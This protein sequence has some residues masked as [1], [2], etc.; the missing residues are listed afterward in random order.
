MRTENGPVS[1]R[2]GMDAVMSEEEEKEEILVRRGG[3]GGGGVKQKDKGLNL[4][5]TMQGT[6]ALPVAPSLTRGVKVR[7]R[8]QLIPAEIAPGGVYLREKKSLTVKGCQDRLQLEKK[9]V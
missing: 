2:K 8:G 7:W 1:A 4:S 6:A 3:G 5:C 9:R